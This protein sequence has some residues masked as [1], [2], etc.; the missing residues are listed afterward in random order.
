MTLI[1]WG[2]CASQYSE[3]LQPVRNSFYEGEVT[4]AREKLNQRVK[5]APEKEKDVLM[6]NDAILE[7]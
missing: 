3:H 6:L 1:L 2:G 5:K 7:M 4:A